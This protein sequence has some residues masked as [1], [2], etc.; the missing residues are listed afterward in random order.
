[1]SGR[2][3]HFLSVATRRTRFVILRRGTRPPSGTQIRH[4]F[5]TGPAWRTRSIA[6]FQSAPRPPRRTLQ[7]AFAA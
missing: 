4:I 5:P 7:N 1:M 2:L 3:G 6:V